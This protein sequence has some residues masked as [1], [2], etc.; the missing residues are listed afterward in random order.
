MTAAMLMILLPD[1]SWLKLWTVRFSLEREMRVKG[2]KRGRAYCQ[3]S[4]VCTPG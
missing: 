4:G 2:A 3:E 1:L